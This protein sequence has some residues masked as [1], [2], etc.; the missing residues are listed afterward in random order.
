MA[1]LASVIFPHRD[2]YNLRQLIKEKKP[3][4]LFMFNL[5]DLSAELLT[6]IQKIDMPKIYR[7]GDSWLLDFKKDIMDTLKYWLKPPRKRRRPE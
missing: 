6:E 3:D 2:S 1:R 5:L 4:L 7:F